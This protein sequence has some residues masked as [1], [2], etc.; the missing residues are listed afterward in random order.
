M[1]DMSRDP[2]W[3]R[4][5][6]GAGEDVHL[7][8]IMAAARTRGY[9]AGGIA[10]TVK[11]FVGY[12]AGEAGRD[13]NTAWIPAEQMHDWHL[14]PFRASLDAGALSVMAA[15]HA[16]N[17]VPA[18]AHRSLMTDLLRRQWGFRGFIVSDFGSIPELIA[19]GV[20]RDEPEACLLYTS[21]SPRD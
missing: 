13:Y 18:T 17:G 6:E 14:P 9:Q 15:F 8:N 5:L 16:V 12:G 10:A 7:A 3:G 2:R 20:A 1:V 4:V 21:P 19:H 11:H